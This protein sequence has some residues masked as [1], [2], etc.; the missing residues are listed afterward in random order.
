M[1][2]HS[3]ET[4]LHLFQ[5]IIQCLLDVVKSTQTPEAWKLVSCDRVKT[6]TFG[7]GGAIRVI[8]ALSNL[9][10]TIIHGRIA[11]YANRDVHERSKKESGFSNLIPI[12]HLDLL[13]QE[14]L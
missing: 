8:R 3:R 10:K 12:A 11:K 14:L 4:Y 13:L 5:P 7:S 1:S 6:I 9:I 2:D